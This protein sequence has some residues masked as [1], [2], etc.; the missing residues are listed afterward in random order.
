METVRAYLTLPPRT[1][2]A[3]VMRDAVV[4]S[5]PGAVYILN[6]VLEA[7]VNRRSR[8]SLAAVVTE[9]QKE[10]PAR[11]CGVVQNHV[12]SMYRLLFARLFTM[13]KNQ[14]LYINFDT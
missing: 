8:H 13:L 14:L 6:T 5:D 12:W 2:A 4:L 11:W 7:R 10:K 9:F 3:E 1:S